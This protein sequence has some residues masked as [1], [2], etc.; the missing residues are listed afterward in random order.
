MLCAAAHKILTGIWLSASPHPAHRI[1]QA[2]GHF[3]PH[4]IVLYR[5]TENIK[6]VLHCGREERAK[7]V[8]KGAGE[9]GSGRIP[10]PWELASVLFNFSCTDEMDFST[11]FVMLF[12]IKMA[13]TSLLINCSRHEADEVQ[14]RAQLSCAHLHQPPAREERLAMP[15]ACI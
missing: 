8:R 12:S 2:L 4:R 11:L 9:R 7:R 6:F 5:A 14:S 1:C 3:Q 10:D 15:F 13:R